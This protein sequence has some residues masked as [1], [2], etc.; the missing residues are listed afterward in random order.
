M[1]E[2]YADAIHLVNRSYKYPQINTLGTY[3]NKVT[4]PRSDQLYICDK[5]S[6]VINA[7][8]SDHKI[9]QPEHKIKL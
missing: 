6:S 8:L 9:S 5:I 7:P 3:E 2:F 1:L 4:V